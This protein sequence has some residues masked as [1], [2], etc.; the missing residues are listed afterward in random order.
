MQNYYEILEIEPNATE[1]QVRE[2]IVQK[3][4][5]ARARANHPNAEK[6][7]E[8]ERLMQLIA[9]AEKHLLDQQSRAA[10]DANL[11]SS[12]TAPAG[13]SAGAEQTVPVQPNEDPQ[14]QA[15]DAQQQAEQMRR[16]MERLRQE[17]RR[18][19]QEHEREL[20]RLRQRVPD[21][22]DAPHPSATTPPT[23]AVPNQP[24][25]VPAAPEPSQKSQKPEKPKKRRASR[26][27]EKPKKEAPAQRTPAPNEPWRTPYRILPQLERRDSD[28]Q[29][30]EAAQA[31]VQQAG[32]GH[33]REAIRE[34]REEYKSGRRDAAIVQAY[35]WA[36][37]YDVY[38]CTYGG[39]AGPNPYATSR[40]PLGLLVSSAQVRLA[41]LRLSQLKRLPLNG[42]AE[43]EQAVQE[44]RG[45][46]SA[47][48]RRRSRLT[49]MGAMVTLFLANYLFLPQ[50]VELLGLS[51]I[52]AD[53]AV[54]VWIKDLVQVIL[55][56]YVFMAAAF[57][58]RWADD[59]AFVK[60]AKKNSPLAPPVPWWYG[61]KR[62]EPLT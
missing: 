36:L 4:R 35:A 56:P 3:R 60:R 2:A 13:G 50:L 54:S 15:L 9:E 16:E 23:Q 12:P 18:K 58:S 24:P 32:A 22:P 44:V 21:A 26:K 43:L 29:Q 42:F 10:Y 28:P 62:A 51:A 45:A 27:K 8:S 37:L 49:L 25:V 46:V 6:R 34:A 48:R 39:F 17:M 33:T 30:L 47:A 1:A 40:S 38:R 57:P 41:Q 31:I 52:P 55:F 11:Q 5:S 61:L 20:E 59:R 53:I 7:H 19:E 14:R